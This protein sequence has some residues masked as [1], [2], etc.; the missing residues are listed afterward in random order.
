MEKA[1]RELQFLSRPPCFFPASVVLPFPRSGRSYL[2]RMTCGLA[3]ARTDRRDRRGASCASNFEDARPRY[4]APVGRG[5]EPIRASGSRVKGGLRSEEAEHAAD[6]SNDL[7]AIGRDPWTQTCQSARTP[8]HQAV[9]RC[10]QRN[11]GHG[12]HG[13]QG[14]S[15]PARYAVEN[16]YCRDNPARMLA[17]GLCSTHEIASITGHKSLKQIEHYTREAN[18]RMLA[19][20]AILKSEQNAKRASSGKRTPAPSGK[21]RPG[22]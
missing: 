8:P 21:R 12:Q 22:S 1:H 20:A 5:N 4:L 3:V 18:Q 14:R 7:R 10:L 13:R 11:A 16:E 6:L 15:R 17:D 19:S 9:A 2:A